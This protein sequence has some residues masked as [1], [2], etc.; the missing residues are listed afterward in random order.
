MPAA[1]RGRVT[2]KR[3]DTSPMGITLAVR[4]ANQVLEPG[5]AHPQRWNITQM[6][7]VN[8]GIRKWLVPRLRNA[9]RELVQPEL[10]GALSA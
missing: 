4:S 1:H 2:R 8:T 7:A 3:F 10:V 9:Q 6:I 5:D